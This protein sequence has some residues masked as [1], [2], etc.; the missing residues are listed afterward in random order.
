VNLPCRVT[1]A[2]GG[3]QPATVTDLSPGGASITGGPAVPAGTRG[4]L[5][6][7]RVGISLPFV[8]R[9]APSRTL[10]VQFDLDAVTEGR[11]AQALERLVGQRAA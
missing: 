4:T 1:V 3:T 9:S 6:A 5:D 2:G 10:H 11:Y 7:D 8:V